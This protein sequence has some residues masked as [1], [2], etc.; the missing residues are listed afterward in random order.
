MTRYMS[1]VV[2]LALMMFVHLNAGLIFY[3]RNAGL[4]VK[5]TSTL[6]IA[7]TDLEP[8]DGTIIRNPGG[9]IIGE[10]FFFNNGILS[11][12][13]FEILLTA[14]YDP[15]KT[16]SVELS[17][18]TGGGRAFYFVNNPGFIPHK[19]E[20]R[21][22]NNRIE[23]LPSYVNND[24][25]T[26]GDSNTTV[27]FALQRELN[28]SI[29]LNGG[30]V[31]LDDD[32]IFDENVK[33]NG[34]G[35]IIF[36]GNNVAFGTETL[37]WTDTI[38]WVGG[39][40]IILNGDAILTS[41]WIFNGN[42]HIIGNNNI[43]DIS[44]GG[45]ILVKSG[46]SLLMSNLNVVGL[47]SGC[48]EFEDKT[49][50]IEL[51]ECRLDMN[52]DYTFT[53]GGFYVSGESTVVTRDKILTYDLDS[54]VTVDST[55]LFYDTLD[56][57][58][59][60]NI[61]T[62]TENGNKNGAFIDGGSIRYKSS[63][64]I[65]DENLDGDTF[66][67]RSIV[68]NRKRNLIVRSNTE[69][70]GRSQSITFGRLA[71]EP[72]VIV[73]AGNLLKFF[74]ILLKDFPIVNTE[75]QAGSQLI[76]GDDTTIELAENAIVDKVFEFEGNV[77]LNGRNKTIVMGPSGKFILRPGAQLTLDDIKIKGIT[78]DKIV[79]YD[80][81]CTMSFGDVE[82][83]QDDTYTFS[84]GQF[85]VLGRWTLKGTGTFEMATEL[86]CTVRSLGTL[87]VARGPTFL[88]TP[89]TNNRTLLRFIDENSTLFLSGGTFAS[90]TTGVIL[91]RGTFAVDS[92][93]FLRNDGAVSISEG[94][95]VGNGI[96]A[97]DLTLKIE[98][99]ATLELL[100]GEFVYQNVA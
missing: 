14:T 35:K 71:N 65:G 42:A 74:N 90:T 75:M 41:R 91:T 27:T 48:I 18:T 33:F 76:F 67:D 63:L 38:E 57:K 46:S 83:T 93:S 82:W 39:Q 81:T 16:F 20:I 30:T 29:V 4:E 44:G 94:I 78:D 15:N 70:D 88:Y 19:L 32:L 62:F 9:A 43:L 22:V 80:S 89:P 17:G 95:T 61:I 45:T 11:D 96:L 47:G 31:I 100:S 40:N 87:D 54:S 58:D 49:A 5:N 12:G 56:F 85:E 50:E 60:D 69:I 84:N 73:Q 97:D 66:L 34:T 86:P 26:L 98:P 59:I 72:I 55:T 1:T 99:A 92:K 7:T 79:M 10:R 52:T 23:G 2:L 53:T 68:I 51:Y 64:K 25:I 77:L 13:D 8:I 24:P 6:Q 37:S 36:D 21:G 28:Q 3:D